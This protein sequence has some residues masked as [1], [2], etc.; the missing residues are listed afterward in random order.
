MPG[1]NLTHKAGL[2]VFTLVFTAAVQ[3]MSVF[4]RVS[5]LK[6]AAWVAP[7]FVTTLGLDILGISAL[8]CIPICT[9]RIQGMQFS[10]IL[11]TL[12]S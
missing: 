12:M 2:L 5:A 11:G 1:I 7:G 3:S 8:P 10:A 4:M 9:G 6:Q